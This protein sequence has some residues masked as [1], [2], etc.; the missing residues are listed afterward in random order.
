[1]LQILDW[2]LGPMKLGKI[3]TFYLKLGKMICVFISKHNN[4]FVILIY[5]LE[6]Q[7]SLTLLMLNL[8]ESCFKNSVDL[9]RLA[10]DQEP[11]CFSILQFD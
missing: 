9:D 5:K 7:T 1:M 8:D 6:S 10:S 4:N 3:L 11:H 2:G